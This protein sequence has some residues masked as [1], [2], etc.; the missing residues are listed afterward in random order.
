[1]S[2]RRALDVLRHPYVIDRSEAAGV[3]YLSITEGR[4]P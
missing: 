2:R 1:V 3:K 4:A